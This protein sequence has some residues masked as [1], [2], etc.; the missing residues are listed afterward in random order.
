MLDE[1]A[2]SREQCAGSSRRGDQGAV[3][4]RIEFPINQTHFLS[5]L[6]YSLRTAPCSLNQRSDA[7]TETIGWIGVGS[8]GHRMV[9]HIA[10]AGHAVVVADAA[11]TDRAP[12]GA[13]IAASNSMVAGLA[14]TIIL[15][16]PD[17]TATEAVARELGAAAPRRV[18][19]VI[20]TSTIGLAAAETAAS[21]LAA[22]G[23]EFV[24]SPVSGGTAG[25]DKAT[26]AVMMACSPETFARLKPLMSLIGTPFHVGTKPGQGQALK[27]LNNFLSATAL[28]ATCEA[29]AFGTRQGIDMKTII[30][31]LNVSTGRNT[32]TDDKFPRRI[33]TGR[34]DAGFTAKLQSK[35]VRLYLE[36]AKAA[37]IANDV[38][39]VV[40]AVWERMAADKPGADLTEMYPYTVKG[41]RPDERG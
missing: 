7:M 20:D 30:E 28:A 11:S 39:S 10:A 29:V 6:H 16:L 22:A 8:I 4:L 13:T 1:A 12:A 27:L 23:I 36:N 38:A 17:G 40:A 19:T 21:L 41:R 2:G 37:G 24:D 25:A 34:Y 32:A 15:S 9:R 14:E 26:L 35:D 33:M 5:K 18:K 31:V 3:A